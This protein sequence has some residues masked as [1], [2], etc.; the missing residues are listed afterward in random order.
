M[1]VWEP[2]LSASPR[3]TD[4]D[5]ARI[6]KRL[7]VTLP[8]DYKSVAR[9]H[10][11]ETP[12]PEVVPAGRGSAPFGVLLLPVAEPG[13]EN[14]TYTIESQIE[15]LS[16]WS[17]GGDAFAKLAPVSDTTGHELICLDYREGGSPSVVL[18]NMDYAAD[19]PK[20]VIRVADSFSDLLGKL[21]D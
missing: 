13:E 6:E 9:A 7:G 2:Y 11:G 15:V 3:P 5:F 18:V 10:A 19:D 1:V 21:R 16:D 14:A 4:A 17:G 12:R 20:A 8:E